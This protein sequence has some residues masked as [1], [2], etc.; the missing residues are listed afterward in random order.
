MMGNRPLAITRACLRAYV[1]KDRAAIEALLDDDFHFTGPI[2]NALDR[3]TYMKICSPNSKLM[4]SFDYIYGC[5]DGDHAFIVYEARTSTGKC[6]R[7]CE[8]HTVRD[9]KLLAT[10]GRVNSCLLVATLRHHVRSLATSLDAPEK[11][12]RA[13]LLQMLYSI[14]SERDRKLPSTINSVCAGH[15]TDRSFVFA[16]AWLEPRRISHSQFEV[17]LDQQALEPTRV[18]GGLHPH[19]YADSFFLKFA[20]ELL[21]LPTLVPAV[22]RTLRFPYPPRRFVVR[23]GCNGRP[24]TWKKREFSASSP[25]RKNLIFKSEINIFGFL[26]PSPWSIGTSKCTQ[27]S[28]GATTYEIN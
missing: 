2:D 15:R 16:L 12:L 9:G 24:S 18:L 5:E 21:S 7:N 4:A 11:L 22:L 27:A 1:D 23:L 14:R 13:Q 6:F 10:G 20:I 8:V 17:E 25:A 3:A 28:R 19:A 26:L